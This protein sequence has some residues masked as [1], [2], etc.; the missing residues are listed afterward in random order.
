MAHKYL[1]TCI[2]VESHVTPA[3]IPR[4]LLEYVI[5]V[6]ILLGEYTS[7]LLIPIGVLILTTVV[8]DSILHASTTG[9]TIAVSLGML[10]YIVGSEVSTT[11]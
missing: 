5:A 9:T 10:L 2:M 4:Y 8:V 1:D 3:H 7:S 11:P 6:L